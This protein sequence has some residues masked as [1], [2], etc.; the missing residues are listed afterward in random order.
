MGS[1]N[2]CPGKCQND[3]CTC[4]P[5]L[6]KLAV[7]DEAPEGGSGVQLHGG[8]DNTSRLAGLLVGPGVQQ[9]VRLLQVALR[10]AGLFGGSR[11]SRQP[12]RAGTSVHVSCSADC[13]RLG[14]MSITLTLKS[15]QLAGNIQHHE[16]CG[17]QV[18]Y[19]EG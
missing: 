4:R 12:R 5:C 7:S 15:V 16:T 1:T 13:H 6:H 19:A 9:V 11:L 10:Q 14:A 18:L 8:G 3:E 2:R 17:S